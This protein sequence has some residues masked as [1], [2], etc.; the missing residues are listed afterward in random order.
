[1]IQRRLLKSW[2]RKLLIEK[3]AMNPS[4]SS[5]CPAAAAVGWLTMRRSYNPA[6]ASRLQSAR[7]LAAVAELESFGPDAAITR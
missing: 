3:Q 5:H 4:S 2:T 1:M 7:L 6:I